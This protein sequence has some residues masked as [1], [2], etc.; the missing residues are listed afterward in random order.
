MDIKIIQGS[1][2]EV[3]CD[4]LIVN[5][6]EGVKKPGGGTGAVDSAI[7][8]IISEYVTGKDDF[9]GKFKDTYVIPT[10][11]KIPAEKILLVGLGKAEDFDLNRVREVA[12]K[13]VKKSISFLKAKTICS[14]VHGAGIA[15]LDPADCAQ[16]ITEGTIIGAYK[17]S[18]YKTKKEENEY[19]EPA[20]FNLVEIDK[21]KIPELNK[22]LEKGKIIADAVNYARDLINEPASVVTPTMLAE[23]AK[24]IQG[25]ECKII[26]RE[27]AEKMGMGA[28]LAV[29]KGSN[30]P[31]KF[32]HMTYKPANVLKK[33]AIIGKGL[34]F[35]SGGL[36]IK[37]ASSMI[38]MKD[39]MSGAAAVL[40][41]M[42]ALSVLKPDI[43]VHGIIAACE[44]MPGGKAYKPGDILKAMNG[45]TIEVDNTDAEGRLTLA[46][47]LVYAE[48]LK[49]DQIIDAATLTGACMVALGYLASGIF[50]NDQELIDSL[51][52]SADKG[53]ERF[54]QLPMYEEYFEGLK[55]DVADFKNSGSRWAG[56]S[57]AA[58]FLKEFV[59]ETPWVHIDIA[60][61]AFLDKDVKE[62]LPKGPSGAC[63]RTFLNYI[64]SLG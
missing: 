1:L 7:D 18:K 24:S 5:L 31:P 59:S 52:K 26:N 46:D 33:I 29:A 63:V 10:Y 19:E 9:K 38:N 44:N 8:N 47:A 30:Q 4:V 17:F 49:V 34:T 39:D 61:P 58:L 64:L 55:S 42:N 23:T 35:D 54:W 62:M 53:G 36:D 25:I 60:G 11:G 6:F 27:E 48:N 41:V 40:G 3:S 14:I 43:E 2:T 37:P 32:I 45:K 20:E 28:Y 51:M 21:N 16:M 50:G 57:S 12:A 13:A 56:A 15:G 22:G